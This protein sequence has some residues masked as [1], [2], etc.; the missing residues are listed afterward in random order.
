MENR[1]MGKKDGITKIKKI[2]IFII[3]FL[4]AATSFGIIYWDSKKRSDGCVIHEE[5]WNNVD[6]THVD[7]TYLRLKYISDGLEVIAL[8]ARPKNL[9]SKHPVVIFNRG[10]NREYGKIEQPT[11]FMY[12]LV[13]N[14]YV[15]FASQY[16][17]NDGGQ[18]KEEFGGRDVHDVLNLIKVA[19]SRDYCDKENI[20]MIGMS[21]GGMMT[22]LAI[23]EGAP[24][25]AAVVFAGV[26]DLFRLSIDTPL[27][28]Q[29]V[30][31]ELIPDIHTAKEREYK[32]RS[33]VY[34]PEKLKLPLLIQHCYQDERVSYAQATD[35]ANKLKDLNY[36]CLFLS[37]D[38]KHKPQEKIIDDAI[39]WLS[40]FC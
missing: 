22:Y 15:V 7:A 14:G 13:K 16:R 18:G 39:H 17:G 23:K 3:F 29:N 5:P 37:Y 11:M 12:R 21:R 6:E 32:K 27:L 36:P 8:E 4:S 19:Q 1:K 30:L 25:K 31:L 2:S 26:T 20:F 34:W 10:G 33:A 35:L 9:N 24:I 38:G 40:Q 28:E